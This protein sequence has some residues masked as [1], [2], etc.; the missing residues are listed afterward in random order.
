MSDYEKT[1]INGQMNIFPQ[2]D[3]TVFLPL[4]LSRKNVNLG[5]KNR[6]N[7]ESSFSLKVGC[8]SA[9]HGILIGFEELSENNDIPEEFVL[10]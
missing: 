8:F 4:A 3:Y 10:F 9:C 1:S 7:N 6:Y 5:F 2:T